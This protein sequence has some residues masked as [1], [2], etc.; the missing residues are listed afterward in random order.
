MDK[1]DDLRAELKAME[2]IAKI[3][4]DLPSAD[5]VVRVAEWIEKVTRTD[6]YTSDPDEP[7]KVVPATT[8]VPPGQLDKAVTAPPDVGGTMLDA[9]PRGDPG[10][11]VRASG[12]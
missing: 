1:F 11:P 12:K 5:S 10:D 2:R 6:F 4:H 9:S 3:L 8:G 7:V